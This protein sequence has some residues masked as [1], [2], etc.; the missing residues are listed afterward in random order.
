[1]LPSGDIISDPELDIFLCEEFFGE[2][3]EFTVA[4]QSSVGGTT[5]RCSIGKKASR[6]PQLGMGHHHGFKPKIHRT[7]TLHIGDHLICVPPYES[8]HSNQNQNSYS[9]SSNP[10]KV[11]EFDIKSAQNKGMPASGAKIPAY[12]SDQLRKQYKN[13]R[14][15]S[16][17]LDDQPDSPAL[18][19]CSP[20]WQRSEE[21]TPPMSAERSDQ[22]SFNLYQAKI[23]NF[24][25]SKLKPVAIA[26]EKPEEMSIESLPEIV[27]DRDEKPKLPDS[28]QKG[29]TKK[30]L[31]LSGIKSDPL[32]E[33]V[34]PVSAGKIKDF[35]S[36]PVIETAMLQILVPD[37]ASV[38]ISDNGKKLHKRKTRAARN[39]RIASLEILK[40]PETD[41]N[42]PEDVS[43]SVA[44]PLFDC[45]VKTPENLPSDNNEATAPMPLKVSLEADGSAPS[46]KTAKKSL[47]EE[48]DTKMKQAKKYASQLEIN[49][50]K[51]SKL[52][53]CKIKAEP[54]R[55]ESITLIRHHLLSLPPSI[56]DLDQLTANKVSTSLVPT[57]Q[58]S[59]KQEFV[60]FIQQLKLMT[61]KYGKLTQPDT[62]SSRS[63]ERDSVT[64][65]TV[66]GASVSRIPE[67]SAG[68]IIK[69]EE[70]KPYAA[71]RNTLNGA[72]TPTKQIRTIDTLNL[73]KVAKFNSVTA[74]KKKKIPSM[75]GFTSSFVPQNIGSAGARKFLKLGSQRVD[76]SLNAKN[77]KDSKQVLTAAPTLSN[78]SID[79]SKGSL[80]GI[81]SR[82]GSIASPNVIVNPTVLVKTMSKLS[83]NLAALT[84]PSNPGYSSQVKLQ[85]FG[86]VQPQSE[87]EIDPPTNQKMRSEKLKKI[88]GLPQSIDFSSNK[89]APPENKVDRMITE[90][91]NSDT[92][93]FSFQKIENEPVGFRRNSTQN[94]GLQ[95][96]TKSKLAIS[97]SSRN[98]N[99]ISETLATRP[100]ISGI[101]VSKFISARAGKTMN[102]NP[103]GRM[104]HS[105]LK[106]A[107]ELEKNRSTTNMM[108]P[109]RQSVFKLLTK[110]SERVK[111]RQHSRDI[112]VPEI[113]LHRSPSE[114]I[115]QYRGLTTQNSL[116]DTWVSK[117]PESR[118]KLEGKKSAKCMKTVTP[119]RI[120]P[121][122]RSDSSSP[123]NI[124]KNTSKQSDSPLLPSQGYLDVRLKPTRK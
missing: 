33:L 104:S 74:N 103:A 123:P 18:S 80:K 111:T 68:S 112:V 30:L 39:I 57:S 82:L 72:K 27:A 83:E 11:P 51:Y 40:I 2:E 14:A 38:A 99:L 87:I 97:Q 91:I 101:G 78:L 88:F 4:D 55:P 76:A 1:M 41:I 73:S 94:V 29:S 95:A 45:R 49:L 119:K 12:E 25:I 21:G 8:G 31:T 3:F 70:A 28:A 6:A 71:T 10:L 59:P 43:G 37:P 100:S 46:V 86:V 24:K 9:Q 44:S 81:R 58:I 96:I 92:V 64:S 60:G 118:V 113:H 16:Y 17:T 48:L 84:K 67:F 50:E 65:Q 47:E 85:T 116:A 102:G 19:S 120:S 7:A 106:P 36:V 122:G 5:L 23:T 20:N 22:G 108:V 75:G 66:Q 110:P 13:A 109:S 35:N 93:N 79:R 62:N 54:A 114:L 121:E 52:N 69:I 15:M 124:Y 53:S 107:V 77:I 34:M 61:S 42:N 26:E 115:K 90:M 89:P 98:L 105:R 32:T 63:I 117:K 56:K